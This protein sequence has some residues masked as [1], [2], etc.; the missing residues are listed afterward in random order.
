MNLSQLE[1]RVGHVR[2]AHSRDT[3]TRQHRGKV[4]AAIEAIAELG[5]LAR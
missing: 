2:R 5:Q 1:Q 4:E 3:E